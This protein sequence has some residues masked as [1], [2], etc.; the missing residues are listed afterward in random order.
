MS[1]A[2]VIHHLF[3]R[4]DR[5]PTDRELADLGMSRA[6]YG[7]LVASAP[8][9]R[10]RMEAIAARFGISPEDIDA[11]RGAALEIAETCG[12]C[13]VRKECQQGIDG[14]AKFETARC[15]N[16]ERYADMAK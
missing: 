12:H 15:P 8:G 6:D 5:P 11:N 13:G 9:T 2:T 7:Q 10:E 4:G 3:S 1:I 14:L 16:A